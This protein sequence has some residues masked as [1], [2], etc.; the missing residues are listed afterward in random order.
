MSTVLCQSCMAAGGANPVS[1]KVPTDAERVTW[2]MAAA[3]NTVGNVAA[4]KAGNAAQ[5]IVR[6]ENL[7]SIDEF[8]ASQSKNL[9]K[10]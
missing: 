10:N 4:L 7:G 5:G 1:G 6:V 9:I 3:A 8:L 2:A